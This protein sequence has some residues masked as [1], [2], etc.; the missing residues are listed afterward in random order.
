MKKS[1]SKQDD[2]GD[3]PEVESFYEETAHNSPDIKRTV[4]NPNILQQ[5]LKR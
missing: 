1:T 3:I 5:K 4:V 2:T